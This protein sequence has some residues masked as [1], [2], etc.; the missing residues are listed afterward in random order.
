MKEEV[1]VST[2]KKDE[3]SLFIYKRVEGHGPKRFCLGRGRRGR[4]MKE[5]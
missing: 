3:V 5:D 2:G 4:T 1:R